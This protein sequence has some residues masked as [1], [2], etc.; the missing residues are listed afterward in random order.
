MDFLWYYEVISYVQH[1]VHIAH[2]FRV[3]KMFYH[4]CSIHVIGADLKLLVGYTCLVLPSEYYLDSFVD[5][6]HFYRPTTFVWMDNN[7]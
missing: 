1:K 6:Q 7:V 3:Q 5:M 4:L 2:I